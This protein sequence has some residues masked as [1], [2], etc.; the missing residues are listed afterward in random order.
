[1]V[2]DGFSRKWGCGNA[3]LNLYA[4]YQNDLIIMEI[5]IFI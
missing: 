4:N 5:F 3:K 2:N 1:M